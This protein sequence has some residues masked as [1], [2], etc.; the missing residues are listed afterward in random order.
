MIIGF[1]EGYN[2][3]QKSAGAI[4]G[5]FDGSSFG[6]ERVAYVASVDKEINALE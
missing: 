2:F 4:A 6:S 1:Q 3:F 5:A